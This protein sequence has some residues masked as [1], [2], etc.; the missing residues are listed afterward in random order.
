MVREV[1]ALRPEDAELTY[2]PLYNPPLPS[3]I[4]VLLKQSKVVE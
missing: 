3:S 4:L 1:A 2:H